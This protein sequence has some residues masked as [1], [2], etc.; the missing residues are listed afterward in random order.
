M[1]RIYWECEQ[2]SQKYTQRLN[3]FVFFHSSLFPVILIYALICIVSGDY[4][5]SK[6]TLA[7]K[8]AVPF[9]QTRVWG[10]FLVWLIQF[11]ST[12][13]YDR[14]MPTITTFFVSCCNYILAMAD[15]LNVL[16]NSVARTVEHM[17][18]EVQP[19]TIKELRLQINTQLCDAIKFQIKIYE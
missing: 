12:S 10:W 16:I 15:H 5:T 14:C 1:H 18:T 4:D 11:I 9:D 13:S 6:W 7:M 8:V 3:Y 2:K 19:K 17:R